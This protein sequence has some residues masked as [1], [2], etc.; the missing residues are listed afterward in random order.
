M[1]L[2]LYTESELLYQ[3]GHR[4]RECR[5]RRNLLQAELASRSG[6]SVSTLK[7]LEGNGQGTLENF[8]K[9]VFALRL[10]N[11]V[12]S[13]FMPQ[14]VSIAQIE[15]LKAPIRQRARKTSHSARKPVGTAHGQKTGVGDK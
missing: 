4:L 7:K 2:I 13:L 15:A 5:L 3:L 12:N 1:A 10:E 9:V 8:M 6:I 14:P 11:E